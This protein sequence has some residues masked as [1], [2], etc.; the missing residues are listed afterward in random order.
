MIFMSKQGWQ[1]IIS[2]CIII[3]LYIKRVGDVEIATY[4]F[5]FLKS[6]KIA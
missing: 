2:T 3:I 4:F 5:L 6:F 1:E